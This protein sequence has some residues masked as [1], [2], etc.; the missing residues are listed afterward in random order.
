MT[1]KTIPTTFLIVP[2]GLFSSVGS[3]SVVYH[4]RWHVR[5]RHCLTFRS[6]RV[7]PLF[8]WSSCNL[9]EIR[10]PKN[11]STPYLQSNFVP[12]PIKG[13]LEF[14][15]LTPVHS[16]AYFGMEELCQI[17]CRYALVYNKTYFLVQICN[18][19]DDFLPF[20]VVKI[21]KK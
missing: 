21:H 15:Y 19:N 16:N 6:T 8:L 20:L 5:N 17:D 2:N 3:S 1:L 14:L 13:I 9:T 4:D 12:S 18:N 7:N 11:V 10:H